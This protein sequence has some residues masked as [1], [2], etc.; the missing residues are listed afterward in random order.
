MA[1][2]DA[3]SEPHSSGLLCADVIQQTIDVYRLPQTKMNDILERAVKRAL[4]DV[5]KEVVEYTARN[6]V[7]G[8]IWAQI[9]GSFHHSGAPGSSS[10]SLHATIRLFDCALK[11]VGGVHAPENPEEMAS[12][13]GGITKRSLD[14]EKKVDEYLC[15]TVLF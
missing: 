6:S 5:W 7:S 10:D 12:F 11:H 3:Q 2:G 15:L 9:R 4:K 1:T 13:K 8:Q 14:G